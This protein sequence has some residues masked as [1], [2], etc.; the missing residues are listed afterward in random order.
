MNACVGC[1]DR[2]HCLDCDCELILHQPDPDLPDRLL[3]TCDA[4]KSW[5]LVEGVTCVPISL[6]A[7]ECGQGWDDRKP[8][9]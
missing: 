1:T 2:I 3:G 6:P 8:E 4:C 7:V 5:F 9:A